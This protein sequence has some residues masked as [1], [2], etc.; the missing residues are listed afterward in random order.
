[1]IKLEE[2]KR[3]IEGNVGFIVEE[4]NRSLSGIEIWTKGV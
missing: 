3:K 2:E 4:G 1:M